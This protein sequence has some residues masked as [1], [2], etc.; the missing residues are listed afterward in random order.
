MSAHYATPGVYKILH[1]CGPNMNPQ[2]PFCL[3]DDYD[4]GR[5]QV[6]TDLSCYAILT[7]DLKGPT[8]LVRESSA[9]WQLS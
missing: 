5:D 7:E 2:R 9:G 3:D 6:D 8:V 1:C 4:T